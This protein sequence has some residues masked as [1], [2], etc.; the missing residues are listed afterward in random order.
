MDQPV[1]TSAESVRIELQIGEGDPK[2]YRLAAADSGTPESGSAAKES[3]KSSQFELVEP[4]LVAGLQ[5]GEG[6]QAALQ[7]EID[8]QT[9]SA[10]LQA[11]QHDDHD[12]G[13][14]H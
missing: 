6:V 4:A 3:G 2:A 13:H 5:I 8:G 1:F 14:D 7:V 11:P 9:L 10:D 12:H